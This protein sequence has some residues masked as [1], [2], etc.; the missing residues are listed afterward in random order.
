[1]LP[2]AGYSFS[3]PIP[4]F[5]CQV[6]AFWT[7]II[8]PRLILFPTGEGSCKFDS[9]A[10]R[11][12]KSVV[13][14]E[15]KML[16]P[17]KPQF[18]ML[19]D[20]FQE[21]TKKYYVLRV[22]IKIDSPSLP[23]YYQIN[24]VWNMRFCSCWIELE[25]QQSICSRRVWIKILQLDLLD[26]P[27]AV[28]CLSRVSAEEGAAEW[29]RWRLLCL[30]Y[31][32]PWWQS[33]QQRGG[34]RFPCYFNFLRFYIFVRGW[35]TNGRSRRA[36]EPLA[37]PCPKVWLI[38]HLNSVQSTQ[39]WQGRN[40]AQCWRRRRRITACSWVEYQIHSLL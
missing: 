12:L 8:C 5:I 19:N 26:F 34:E 28:F 20:L 31:Y 29:R 16:S 14:V 6:S 7:K 35:N 30:F 2:L 4:W 40:T 10:W 18:V 1:M 25:N 24:L 36:L 23:L 11:S 15:L 38:K 17:L 32:R 9:L 27:S 22:V 13:L 37:R 33:L 21:A 3:A 39:T